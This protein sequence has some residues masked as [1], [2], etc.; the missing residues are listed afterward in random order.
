MRLALFLYVPFKSAANSGDRLP[1]LL[2]TV[3][4]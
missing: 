2:I 1:V 3:G 4:I